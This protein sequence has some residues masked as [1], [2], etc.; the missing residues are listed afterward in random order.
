MPSSAESS[1]RKIGAK[2]EVITSVN[3]YQT[4][5]G[6]DLRGLKAYTPCTTLSVCFCIL[7]CNRISWGLPHLFYCVNTLYDLLIS[8]IL[9]FIHYLFLPFLSS[10]F[11]PLRVFSFFN[12]PVIPLSYSSLLIIN[13]PRKLE[14]IKITL[15]WHVTPC[16]LVETPNAVRSPTGRLWTADAN[17][18]VPYRAHAAPQP[19]CVV[20]LRSRFQNGM[21]G[22]RHGHGMACVNQTRSNCVNQMRMIQSKPLAARHGSGTAWAWHAMCEITYRGFYCLHQQCI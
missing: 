14:I 2:N 12:P 5:R 22:A 1:S 17:S 13:Q 18:H 20:A 9:S 4:A 16:I 21:V 7:K 15:L 11:L 19:C 3:I 8:F 6:A 10:F